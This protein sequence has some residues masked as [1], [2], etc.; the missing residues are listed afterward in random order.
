M[1]GQAGGR[2]Y[3]IQAVI[4][5]LDAFHDRDWTECVLE[6]MLGADKVDL[7]FRS[8]SGDR[9]SQIKSSKNS[10]DVADIRNWAEELEIAYPGAKQHELFL[11]GPVTGGAASLTR[12]GKVDIPILQPLNI[13]A[14]L[15]QCAHRLDRYLRDLGHG[16]TRPMAR[17]LLAQAFATRLGQL[18]ASG[19]TLSR[20]ALEELLAEWVA[21]LLPPD[22]SDNIE[23]PHQ[24]PGPP[25][26]FVGRTDEIELL[27]QVAKRDDI[28]VVI[29]RGLAGIRKS[30]LAVTAAALIESLYPDGQIYLD[31]RGN[32]LQSHPLTRPVAQAIR[33][34]R[35]TY[36]VSDDAAR[37]MCDF[38]SLLNGRRVLILVEN[39][40]STEQ[41]IGLIPPTA[42]SLI[43]IITTQSRFDLPGAI[44]LDLDVLSREDGT[45]LAQLIAPRVTDSAPL[46]AEICGYLP[47]A[48]RIACGTLNAR[49]DLPADEYIERLTGTSERAKLVH[50]ALDVSFT[51]ISA[52]IRR[53]LTAAAAFAVDFDADGLSA[54]LDQQDDVID[55]QLGIAIG[56][57]LIEWDNKRRRYRLHDL[58]RAYIIDITENTEL[59]DFTLD[60]L[61]TIPN[62]VATSTIYMERVAIPPS[63]H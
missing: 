17:E 16:P 40:E 20:K 54:I 12:V 48:I 8:T 11:I 23:V 60:T 9:V 62:C 43:I 6:P 21:E 39:V 13:E 30:A 18:A 2:G 42:N 52:E 19:K 34:F 31:L 41:V 36:P 27:K 50:A 1:S 61:I 10:I 29:V 49:P 28:Q 37:C 5:V 15:E 4:A 63:S 59:S 38:R 55:V 35:P 44:S 46:L 32:D 57:H 26:D 14:L 24:L 53:F 3:L 58:V 25:G 47:L 22:A 51:H 45:N 33:A 7:L 56:R